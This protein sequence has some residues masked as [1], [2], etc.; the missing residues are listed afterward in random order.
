MPEWGFLGGGG[1]RVL[2]WSGMPEWA[3][4]GG[5]QSSGGERNARVGLL[6]GGDR[7][8]LE[9]VLRLVDSHIPPCDAG[10]IS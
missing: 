7:V 1:D 8:T 5:G 9:C 6:G 2:E 4:R 3:P 10:I